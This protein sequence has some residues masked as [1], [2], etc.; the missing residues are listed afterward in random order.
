VAGAPAPANAD[1]DAGSGGRAHSGGTPASAG[2][3]RGRVIVPVWALLDGD[4]PVSGA[5]VR[6]Y[7][8]GLHAVGRRRPL[9]QRHGARTERT[10]KSG[11]ALLEFARLP[12]N[13]TVVV[14]GG[15]S[16]G[17]RL[18]GFLSARVRGYR[19]GRVVHVNPVT[20]LVEL[21]RRVNPRVSHRRATRAVSRALGI[22]SWADNVDLRASDRWLDGER[23]LRHVRVHA[24]LDRAT[25]DLLFDIRRGRRTHRFRARRARAAAARSLGRLTGEPSA[26]QGGPVARTAQADLIVSVFARLAAGVLSGVASK[27]GGAAVGWVLSAFGLS[28]GNDLLRQDMANIRQALDELGKQV[29]QVQN[30][31]EL[32]GFSELVHQTDRTIGEIDHAMSQLALLANLPADDPTKRGFTRTVVDYIGSHLLDAPAIL[33]QNLGSNVP[34]ADNLIKSASRLLS[35]R[36]RFFDKETSD[37]VKSVYDYFAG[38]QAKLAILLVEYYHAKPDT[39]STTTIK[40]DLDRIE[41]NVTAQASSLKPRVPDGTVV[42]TKTGRMWM[43]T[44]DGSSLRKLSDFANVVDINIPPGHPGTFRLTNA[45]TS[46]R[47]PGLPFDNWAMPDAEDLYKLL[48]HRP[49]GEDGVEFLAKRARISRQLLDAANSHVWI[50]DTFSWPVATRTGWTLVYRLFSLRADV[51]AAPTWLLIREIANWRTYFDSTD[52]QAILYRRVRAPGEDYWWG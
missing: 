51:V 1:A 24:T 17:R 40:A 28:D 29:T 15:S 23:F 7:A 13:F 34:L 12:R 19:A 16:E 25:G 44:I 52:A 22:P 32:A 31:V 14:S 38:Y 30:R 45:A 5:R 21:W 47:V 36:E 27:A 37:Q 18:R 43:Q 33:N 26:L 4:T 50:R 35:V 48:S 11:V 10:Y 3:R 41:G 49:E 8:G 20:T 9:R 42:D 39:Y 6:V 2:E 46:T